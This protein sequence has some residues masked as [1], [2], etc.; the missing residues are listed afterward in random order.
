MI[1]FRNLEKLFKINNS[2]KQF[3][4]KLVHPNNHK[5]GSDLCNHYL[6]AELTSQTSQ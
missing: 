4:Y 3:C 6:R 5:N 2:N 1:I